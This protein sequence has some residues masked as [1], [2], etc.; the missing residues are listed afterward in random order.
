MDGISA[1]GMD[2]ETRHSGRIRDSGVDAEV[3]DEPDEVE[4]AEGP[5]DGSLFTILLIL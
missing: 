2:A 1:G 3:L 4:G 5:G